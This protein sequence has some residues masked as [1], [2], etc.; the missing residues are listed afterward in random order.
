MQ[1]FHKICPDEYLSEGIEES[2]Y[3]RKSIGKDQL[4]F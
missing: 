3:K 4:T 1:S 2:L